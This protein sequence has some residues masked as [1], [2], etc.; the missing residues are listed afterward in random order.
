M[1]T[2]AQ[3]LYTWEVPTVGDWGVCLWPWEFVSGQP[4][5]LC[6]YINYQLDALIIIYS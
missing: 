3:L 4:T 2:M 1:K 6:L 5:V